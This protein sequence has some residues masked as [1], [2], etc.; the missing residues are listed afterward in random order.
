MA[1]DSTQEI[2]HINLPEPYL[3]V[4]IENKHYLIFNIFLQIL[5]E[6]RITDGKGKFI[7]HSKI[8]S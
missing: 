5:D 2:C 3:F 7:Q 4:S 6:G 8:P 1:E